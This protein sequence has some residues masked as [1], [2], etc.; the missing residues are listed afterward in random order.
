M[1]CVVSHEEDVD[2]VAARLRETEE[3]VEK[4][5]DVKRPFRPGTSG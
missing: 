2:G 5:L 1:L 3:G 4:Y